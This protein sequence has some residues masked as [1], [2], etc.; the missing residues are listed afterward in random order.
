MAEHNS[1]GFIFFLFALSVG[2]AAINGT[3][4]RAT[5]ADATFADQR[6]LF[7][8]IFTLPLLGLALTLTYPHYHIGLVGAGAILGLV[9]TLQS[10]AAGLSVLGTE[11]MAVSVLYVMARRST[12]GD[13]VAAMEEVLSRFGYHL[14]QDHVGFLTGG[15]LVGIVIGFFPRMAI[16]A[17]KSQP[18]KVRATRVNRGSTQQRSQPAKVKPDAPTF[19]KRSQK[20]GLADRIR[21]VT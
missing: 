18:V 13:S 17:R 19:S 4:R 11:P 20:S 12:T 1:L 10:V 5:V 8:S 16:K 21:S 3:M 2:F 7:L 15:I 14:T 6:K 9:M